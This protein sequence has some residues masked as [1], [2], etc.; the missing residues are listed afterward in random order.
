MTK[1]SDTNNYQDKRLEQMESSVKVINHEMGSIKEDVSV[2]KTDFKWL[3]CEFVK[4]RTALEEIKDKL[5]QRP[6]W[7][8]ATSFSVLLSA[9]VGFIVYLVTH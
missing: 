2:L 8:I 7:I 3:K 6:T 1:K 5:N 9:L 4:M